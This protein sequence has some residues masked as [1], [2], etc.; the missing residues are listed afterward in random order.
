MKIATNTT[1][2]E[3]KR[4][5]IDFNA[6]VVADGIRTLDQA[7]EDLLELVL[8]TASGRKTRTEEKGYREISIFKDGV[9]L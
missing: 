9:T 3:N 2:A 6:G 5:W 8:E 7:G 4:G 1:L